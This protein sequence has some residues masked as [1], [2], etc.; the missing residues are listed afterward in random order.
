[1]DAPP[2]FGLR[3]VL[4]AAALGAAMPAGAQVYKWV[5]AKGAVTY[6]NV[7][8]PASGAQPKIIDA[9]PD[10]VT[11]YS[12]D[13]K[14]VE[15]MKPDPARDAKVADLERELQ[16]AKKVNAAADMKAAQTASR[17]ASFERCIAERRMDCETLHS[18]GATPLLL[19][20]AAIVVYP[21]VIVGQARKPPHR[22]HDEDTTRPAPVGTDNRPKVGIDSRP[23]V[24]VDTRP[25][26]GLDERTS[27][28]ASQGERST[29]FRARQ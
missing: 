2:I 8:P 25:K 26:V 27:S 23:K 15:A 9:V 20:D 24:G 5:D 18:G 17:T 10:R 6:S 21:R 3:A 28:T 19:P 1:M 4:L 14:L 29:G 7:P 22:K 12:P 11:V 16:A 13:A